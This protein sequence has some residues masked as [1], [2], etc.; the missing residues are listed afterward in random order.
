MESFKILEREYEV[1][2]EAFDR[3]KEAILKREEI[4]NQN[5]PN[6]FF[7]NWEVMLEETKPDRLALR[8]KKF[9]IEKLKVVEWEDIP[10]YG[11]HMTM[12]DFKGYCDGGGFIDYDGSGNYASETHMSNIS[13]SPSDFKIN[14]IHKNKDFTHIVWFNK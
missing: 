13:I 14:N 11:D 2:S 9:E 7:Q 8:N 12:E 5:N 10:E 3:K 1:L 4:K 6:K